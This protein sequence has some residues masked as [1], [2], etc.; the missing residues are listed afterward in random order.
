MYDRFFHDDRSII[1][2][3]SILVTDPEAV[4]NN[5]KR[6]LRRYVHIPV[7]P[8]SRTLKYIPC[9]TIVVHLQSSAADC[10]STLCLTLL[11]RR[12]SATN[13]NV[14]RARCST[15]VQSAYISRFHTACSSSQDTCRNLKQSPN[16]LS[17]RKPFLCLNFPNCCISFSFD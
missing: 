6:V 9:W 11:L 16:C 15:A 10:L 3:R 7:T 14:T 4:A 13:T 5:R 1:L 17:V 8:D 2:Y 12:R